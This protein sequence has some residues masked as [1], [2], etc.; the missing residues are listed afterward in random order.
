[1]NGFLRELD[2]TFRR[3]RESFRPR[4]NKRGGTTDCDQ[5]ARGEYF[6]VD[7]DDARLGARSSS[8]REPPGAAAPAAAAGPETEPEPEP[9]P[10]QSSA[11]C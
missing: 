1:M 11:G 8:R 9:E 3:D 7:E 10:E 6:V 5:K 4:V 2:V